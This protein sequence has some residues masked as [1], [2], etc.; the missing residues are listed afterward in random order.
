MRNASSIIGT[1]KFES[2][3]VNLYNKDGPGTH[4]AAYKKVVNNVEY[5]DICGN[6][7]AP[8]DLF[9]YFGVDSIK[10]NH[11]RYQNYDT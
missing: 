5:F 3:I 7:R 10:Y 11:D 2:A 1:R 9:K 8:L 6:L 4:W